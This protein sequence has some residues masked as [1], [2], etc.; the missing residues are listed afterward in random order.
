MSGSH[1]GE[2]A[3]GGSYR[4]VVCEWEG[5]ASPAQVQKVH[6]DNHDSADPDC[7][8]RDYFAVARPDHG[9]IWFDSLAAAKAWVEANLPGGRWADR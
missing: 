9:P 2:R 5:A 3:W 6:T 1:P 8:P 7:G 4:R